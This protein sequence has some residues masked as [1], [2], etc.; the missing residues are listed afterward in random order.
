MSDVNERLVL[1]PN[2][3]LSCK[4]SSL[5]VINMTTKLD[6]LQLSAIFQSKISLALTA[7]IRVRLKRLTRNKHMSLIVWSVSDE[8]KPVYKIDTWSKLQDQMDRTMMHRALLVF[9]FSSF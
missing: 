1:L 8:D 5:L 9:T 2:I 7:H 4:H 3:A 6:C